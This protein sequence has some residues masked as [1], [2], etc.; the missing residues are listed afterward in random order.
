MTFF[1]WIELEDRQVRVEVTI[2]QPG[3]DLEISA[4]AAYRMHS[5]DERTHEL[6]PDKVTVTR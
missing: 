2:T 3:T 1:I 6:S 4:E 5:L